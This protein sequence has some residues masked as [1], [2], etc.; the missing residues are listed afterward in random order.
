MSLLCFLT[1]PTSADHLKESQ[2]KDDAQKKLDAIGSRRKLSASYNRA[3]R[4]Q[5]VFN[6][7]ILGFHRSVLQDLLTDVGGYD[8]QL[9]NLV[10][11]LMIPLS[12]SQQ[13]SISTMVAHFREGELYVDYNADVFGEY[14]RELRKALVAYLK[15]ETSV[16]KNGRY[17]IQK[18]RQRVKFIADQMVNNEVYVDPMARDRWLE[19]NQNNREEYNAVKRALKEFFQNILQAFQKASDKIRV[20]RRTN[21]WRSDRK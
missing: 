15:A 7:G 18:I 11:D 10:Q 8:E 17:G 4:G 14:V 2:L 12:Q 3:N 6:N 13:H 21:N 20:F 16:N 1:G 9:E 5:H 19:Q